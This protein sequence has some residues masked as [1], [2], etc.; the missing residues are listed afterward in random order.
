MIDWTLGKTYTI[1]IRLY[2]FECS[3]ILLTSTF[4]RN[5]DFVLGT[6]MEYES[7]WAYSSWALSAFDFVIS[8][9]VVLFTR[10]A[11]FVA[12]VFAVLPFVS[13]TLISSFLKLPVEGGKSARY[14]GIC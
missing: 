10:F 11:C 5:T 1:S 2:K 7:I 4:V 9:Y 8:T 13:G 3:A 14:N 6:E 12:S